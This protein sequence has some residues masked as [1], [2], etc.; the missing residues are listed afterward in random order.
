[1]TF[2]H[3]PETREDGHILV[4]QKSKESLVITIFN[5]GYNLQKNGG[6]QPSDGVEA[7]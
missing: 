7:L 6:F 2:G 1:M 5:K 3:I 4:E